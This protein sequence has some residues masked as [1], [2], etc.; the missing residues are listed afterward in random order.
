M[1]TP[2]DTGKK[3]LFMDLLPKRDGFPEYKRPS[4][5]PDGHFIKTTYCEMLR[6]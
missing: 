5:E 2:V 1:E 4:G 6:P 3:L